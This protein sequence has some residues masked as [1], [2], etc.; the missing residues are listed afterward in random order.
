[1]K[2]ERWRH[3]ESLFH[4]ARDRAAAERASFL[5]ENC[6]GDDELR[7][8]VESLLAEHER[9]SHSME[10]AASDLAVEWSQSTPHILKAGTTLGKYRIENLLGQGGMGAVFLAYD[11]I[12]Q[13]RLALKVLKSPD[14]DASSQVQLLREA[15][16]ASALNHPNV[17]TIYEV[18]E[19][20]DW[21]FI[22][23]EYIDG[24]TLCDV[25]AAA[26]LPIEDSVR[27]GI[28]IA[29]ALA[30]AHDRGVIH[31]DLKAA[32]VIVS[33]SGH[34]KIVDFGLARRANA[35]ESQ[36]VTAQTRSS[37]AVGTPY[38]MAPEQV[39]GGSADAR[40]DLWALGV[41]LYEMLTAARPFGG[42]TT[43]D[44]FSSI[45]RDAPVPMPP[46]TPG[47]LRQLVHKC[48]SK[49]PDERYQRAADVRLG[50]ETIASVLRRDARPKSD[51]RIATGSALPPPP[52]IGTAGA[53]AFVGRES[54]LAKMSS[55]WERAKGGQRQVIL[56]G[57]EPGIGKTR[58]SMEFARQRIAEGATVLVGRSEE[59]G[60]VP[61][62]SF[63]EALHW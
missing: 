22:A 11:A 13:R 24:R 30:H 49:S 38:A 59:E 57:G 35:A 1:M 10:S 6:G 56:L 27:Y 8:E 53:V 52:I 55:V 20:S 16:S 28:E 39:R 7:H 18:G 51:P 15:R 54:E 44:L 47:S 43:A 58:L 61:Y 14:E 21:P 62:Q 60:L 17:C 50:L 29:D 48:L 19:E 36:S 42:G 33:S 12:L 32:N 45:L 41:L 26:P 3:I 37:L 2:P 34:L 25:I 5:T 9:G 46:D 31:R 23:M 4:A 63:V 40:T